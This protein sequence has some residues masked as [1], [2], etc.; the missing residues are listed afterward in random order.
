MGLKKL[1]RSFLLV[2]VLFS[3][4]L[5]KSI[6]KPQYGGTL[7]IG[8]GADASV[9]VPMLASDS[10]SHDVCDLIFLGVLKLNPQLKVVGDVAKTYKISKDQKTITFYLKKGVKWQDGFPVTAKDV[11]F[12]YKLITNPKVPSPYSSEFKE[13]KEFK[14]VSPY[15]F[16]VVYKRPFAPALLSWGNLVI[17]PEHLLKGKSVYYLSQVFGRKP[18][19][20]GPFVLEKWIPQTEIVLRYNPLY[21]KGRPYLDKIIYKIIPDPSTM[22]MEL[23]AG[24]VDWISLTPLQYLQFIR[25]KKLQKRFRVYKFPSFSFTY[26]G[27]N[28][29][30]WLFKSAEVR[31]ALCYAINKKEIVKGALLGQGL[32]AYGPY[33]PN[34]WYYNPSIKK[35][36]YYDPRKAKELLKKA[37]FKP[38][39]GG[40]LYKDGRPFE[41]TLLVPQGSVS[42][43]LTAQ[44][45]QQ[46]LKKLGI[47]VKIRVVEWTTLINQFIIPRHFQAVILGWVL[48]PDP[49]IYELF[50][51]SQIKPPGFN[52]V[53]YSNPKLDELLD[54]GRHTFD[55]QKRKKIYYEVQEI[56]ARD[57]PYTFLYIPFSLEAVSK[58]IKGI[59]PSPIGIGYNIERWWIPKRYQKRFR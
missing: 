4:T 29:K 42:R 18:V 43:L 17:L 3:T 53:G 16:K 7:I 48:S 57:Q 49:D 28:L 41:F 58:R 38:G 13:V 12:A 37:G 22:F 59:K 23:K 32:P 15:E 56:L 31:R 52:F 40:V 1:L 21:Y 19:G 39:K 25:D 51:S 14:L 20:N 2:L 55:R 5:A 44:I 11:Y 36:C 33:P 54:E 8:I 9:L 27:Y 10:I 26:L 45:I 47:K 30:F 24:G 50:H 46:Q 35:I 34:A 6:L